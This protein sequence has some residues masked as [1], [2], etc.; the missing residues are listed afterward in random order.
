ML[1]TFVIVFRETLEAALIV[2]IVL[3]AS[4]GIAA[5][6]GWVTAGV[7]AGLAGAGLVALFADGLANL[8]EGNGTEIFNAVVLLLAVAMLA[9]HQICMSG[10]ARELVDT[11]RTVGRAVKEGAKPLS[12]LAAICAVAVLREGSETVLF[13]YGLAVDGEM[14]VASMLQ[15]G[16]LGVAAAAIVGAL[17]YA[18]LLSVPL[19]HIFRV[20]GIIIVLLAAGLAA[21]AA[22][23]LV[24]AG[25][26]P[27]LGYDIW[28]TSKILPQTDALGFLLHILVGYVA[29]P[30]GIQ[31]V[32]YLATVAAIVGASVAVR[33]AGERPR[34]A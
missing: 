7:A 27:A 16:L 33:R 1:S 13:L 31:I 29:R 17:F 10:H 5:R 2:A 20:T 14:T 26:L 25:W 21:Q 4:K 15:G 34:A 11:S 12:A 6:G 28:N 32:F 9:W 23:F 19:K 3:A 18:G 8:F 30:E 22:A 24:Q